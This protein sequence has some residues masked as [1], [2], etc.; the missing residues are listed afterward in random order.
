[1]SRSKTTKKIVWTADEIIKKHFEINIPIS[2]ISDYVN[3]TKFIDKDKKFLDA[4]EVKMCLMYIRNQLVRNSASYKVV[5]QI[6]KELEVK[7]K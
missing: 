7:S 2:G 1:M 5:E 6:E 4:D 3:K